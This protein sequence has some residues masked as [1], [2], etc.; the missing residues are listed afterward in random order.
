MKK[1]TA[2][3]LIVCTILLNLLAG[4]DGLDENY[5]TNPNHRLSF[6][7]DTLSFDTVFTTIGSATKQFMVYNRND[8]PLNIEKVLQ[9]SPA[10]SGFRINVDGRKGDNFD[11]VRVAA[12]DSMYIFV[13]VTVNPNGKDQPLLVQDSIVFFFNGIK[14][15]VLL[16]ACGQDVHLIKGGK[17]LTEDTKL[18][19]ERPYLIYD[20]LTIDDGVTVDIEEG[21]TFYMHDKAKIISKGTIIANGTIEKPI[22]F[23]GDRLDFI[24]NDLLPYDRT[25]GQWEGIT[26]KPES[27]GNVFN[28]VIVRNGNNGILCEASDPENS[29]LKINNSQITNMDGFAFKAINCNIEATNSEFT[30]ATA[31][32]VLLAGGKYNFTHCTIANYMTLK[33]RT[34]GTLTIKDEDADTKAISYNLEQAY[35]DNCIID[36]NHSA[37]KD[38]TNGELVINLKATPLNGKLNYQFNHCVIKLQEI[39]DDKFPDVIFITEKDTN[40]MEYRMTG[41]DKNKYMYDFRPDKETTP[42]VGKADLFITQK[43]PIDRNGVNRLTNDGPD[44]GAYEYVPKEEEDK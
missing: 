7:T 16:E 22:T 23:R 12:K 27:F 43:Y 38:L 35:F 40:K 29:K 4:C 34:G 32:V 10:T 26:F 13:E 15:S 41:G 33:Q 9:A 1:I 11:N 44:I 18:T 42:G 28:N 2:P 31:D 20:S 3:L 19:A 36:G 25:P 17:I 30:N 6:S 14:Q 37:A 5:S 8:Q 24:L 39:K 21:A